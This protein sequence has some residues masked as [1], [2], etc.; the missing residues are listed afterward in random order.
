MNSNPRLWTSE[1]ETP[2]RGSY[3]EAL[4]N[5]FLLEAMNLPFFAAFMP[6]LTRALPIQ[7]ADL[8]ILGCYVGEETMVPDGDWNASSLK[9]I[10]TVRLGW[11]IMV[12]E[13]D[14]EE[15]ERRLD[16]AYVALLDGLWRNPELTSFLDTTDPVT[17]EPTEYN[18]RFEGVMFQ[19]A[20][21]QWGAVFLDNE[22]PVAEKQ[23]DVTLRYR[24]VFDPRLEHDLEEVHLTTAFPPG[25]TPEELERIQQVRQRLILNLIPP[26]KERHHG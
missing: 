21:T 14:K 23:W 16:K 2:D 26:R 15:A 17:G 12:A 25:R 19:R 1:N 4:R 24:R 11:S 8:P 3:S 20:I 7:P 22:T 13:S 10:V 6:R 9:F 5:R 18:A